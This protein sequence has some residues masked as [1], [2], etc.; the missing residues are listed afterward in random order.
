MHI[1]LAEQ[2]LMEGVITVNPNA[3]P[4]LIKLSTEVNFVF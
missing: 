1:A 4:N 2:P 3:W